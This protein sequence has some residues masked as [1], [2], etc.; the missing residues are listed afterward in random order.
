VFQNE[1]R[2]KKKNKKHGGISRRSHNTLCFVQ[3][4][5]S[6]TA[7]ELESYGDA[8]AVVE[9]VL[10]SVRTVVAFGGEDKEVARLEFLCSSETDMNILMCMFDERMV[11]TEYD[12]LEC[13]TL[14]AFHKQPREFWNL[15][16]LAGYNAV[17]K[18]VFDN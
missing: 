6:L 3:V 7:Q 10:S 14:A 2:K 15:V 18:F 5:S 11:V 12:A 8:G 9:E 13:I 17:W 1:P 4:Q 16:L